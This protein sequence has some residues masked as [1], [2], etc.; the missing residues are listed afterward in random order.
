MQIDISVIIPLYNTQKYIGAALQSVLAQSKKNVQL[1]VVDDGSTDE[2]VKIVGA[3]QKEHNSIELYRQKNAGPASARNHG[4]KRAK[5]KYLMFMDSDDLLPP[6]A[7]EDLYVSI[8]KNSAEITIGMMISFRGARQWI[9]KRMQPFIDL[10]AEGM[11]L[12]SFPE[13]IN[14]VSP[15][16][17]LYRKDFILK[18]TLHFFE[19]AHLSEDLYFVV[20]AFLNASSVNVIPNIVYNYRGREAGEDA[21][22]DQISSQVFEDIVTVSNL[23]DKQQEASHY[24]DV[25]QCYHDRYVNETNSIVYRLW[26]YVQ[27]PSDAARTLLLLSD[28][29]NKVG[30]KVIMLMKPMESIVLYKLKQRKY[31]IVKKLIIAEKKKK[32]TYISKLKDKTY[33]VLKEIFWAGSLSVAPLIQKY[34]GIPEKLWLIGE[35]HG[36]VASDTGYQFFL[37]CRKVFP[38]KPIYFVTKKENISTEVRGKVGNIIE[39]GSRK[40]FLFALKTEVY[41]FSDGYKD[42]F[43]YW[44]RIKSKSHLQV[45]VFLQHGIFAFKRSEYYHSEAVA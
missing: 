8:S 20:N 6:D 33:S 34:I 21:L 45:S 5:G 26:P 13:L 15:C 2:S 22:T 1:I 40:N 35:Q 24:K 28:Y 23:L 30:D 27:M 36:N 18:Y 42:I 25:S 14:N 43:P 39:Y 9:P 16:N 10:E 31:D 29:L 32:R 4:M 12:G 41:I 3:F 19:D 11:N 38:E 17:K 7:L 44:S 37:Y